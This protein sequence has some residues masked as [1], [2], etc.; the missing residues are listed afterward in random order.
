MVIDGARKLQQVQI[1]SQQ[2]NKHSFCLVLK[3]NLQMT[4]F[5][6][7]S[8]VISSLISQGTKARLVTVSALPCLITS[9]PREILEGIFLK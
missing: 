7:L 8:G 5:S 1:W 2:M 4:F 3:E 9:V 6:W